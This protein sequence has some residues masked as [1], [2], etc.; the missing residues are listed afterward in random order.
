[1]EYYEDEIIKTQ[2]DGIIMIKCEADAII[3]NDVKV[4]AA[5]QHWRNYLER[6]QSIV[7]QLFCGQ[8]RYLLNDPHLSWS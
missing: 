4:K 2:E 5:R 3:H 1:M 7:V 6:N 8:T